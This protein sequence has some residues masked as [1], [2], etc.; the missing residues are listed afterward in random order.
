M[1]MVIPFQHTRFHTATS[2]IIESRP[3]DFNAAAVVLFDVQPPPT[4]LYASIDACCA[5]SR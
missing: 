3:L 4:A 5:V 2:Q 1:S